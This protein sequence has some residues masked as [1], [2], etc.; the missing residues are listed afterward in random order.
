MCLLSSQG[1]ATVVIKNWDP[2]VLGPALAIDTV[3][4]RSCRK[5][6]TQKWYIRMGDRMHTHK[7]SKNSACTMKTKGKNK[8]NNNTD[9][10]QNR[11]DL[12]TG[13]PIQKLRSMITICQYIML[14]NVDKL[15]GK[16]TD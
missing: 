7:E 3:K 2:F 4:G 12:D 13:Q 11:S 5:L 15:G 14:W 10:A 8:N 1:V 16:E 6:Q 9:P